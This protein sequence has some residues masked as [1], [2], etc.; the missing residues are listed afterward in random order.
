MKDRTKIVLLF[1]MIFLVWIVKNFAQESSIPDYTNEQYYLMEPPMG[2]NAQYA[3]QFPDG[4]GD[5]IT[6]V[7]IEFGWNWDHIDLRN[8]ASANVGSNDNADHGTSVMGILVA[9]ENGFGITGFAPHARVY[10]IAQSS[11]DPDITT[12]LNAA[13]SYSSSPL[14]LRILHLIQWS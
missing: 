1:S 7:D 3:W 6:I 8:N 11:N 13:V 10:G 5:G 2:M 14:I 9:E 4:K 12:A